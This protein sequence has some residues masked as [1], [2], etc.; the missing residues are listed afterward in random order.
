[1]GCCSPGGGYISA[2]RRRG[3]RGIFCDCWSA[4]RAKGGAQRE[5]WSTHQK[6]ALMPCED[7]RLSAIFP[8]LLVCSL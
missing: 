5:R 8:A 3:L 2:T 1:M 6:M 7:F 4:G